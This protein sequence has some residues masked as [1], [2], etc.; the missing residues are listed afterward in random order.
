M[1]RRS[2]PKRCLIRMSL[3]TVRAMDVLPIPPGP[4][5]ANGVRFSA[6]AVSFPI[7]S[8]RPKKSLGGGGESSPGA[9][10]TNIRYLFHQQLRLLTWLVS[11]W[12]RTFINSMK[13]QS[14]DATHQPRL[15]V[16]PFLNLQHVTMHVGYKQIGIYRKLSLRASG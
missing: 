1:N 15:I 13:G 11:R 6:R 10:D 4:M 5:R 2:P 9:L 16:S 14:T 12:R 7:N 3:R 8:S